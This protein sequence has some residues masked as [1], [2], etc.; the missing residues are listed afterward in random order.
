MIGA[1]RLREAAFTVL[2]D[3]RGKNRIAAQQQAA[4]FGVIGW[5]QSGGI[6]SGIRC[7]GSG[8]RCPGSGIR[9]PGSG[10]RDPETGNWK[11]ETKNNTANKRPQP[12]Y[13][14]FPPVLKAD[15]RS[16]ARP[17]AGAHRKRQVIRHATS[18]RAANSHPAHR[19]PTKTNLTSTLSCASIATSRSCASIRNSNSSRCRYR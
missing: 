2:A 9:C 4:S 12:P 17:T 10:I 5:G 7:P 11:L 16:R 18:R 6:I 3:Q 8:I 1:L 14:L 19:P 13:D 15:G